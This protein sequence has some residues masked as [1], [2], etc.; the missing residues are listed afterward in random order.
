MRISDWSS[1]V[2]SSDLHL[3][4]PLNILD[5]FRQAPVD[6]HGAHWE[7]RG[8][9]HGLIL[10]FPDAALGLGDDR[11]HAPL[12]IRADIRHGWNSSRL[13]MTRHGFGRPPPKRSQEHTSEIQ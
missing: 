1:D 2:C 11:V 13:S 8:G 6:K 5:F 10:R 9:A 4:Q 3:E 12:L 7:Q